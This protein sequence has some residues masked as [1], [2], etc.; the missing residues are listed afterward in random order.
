MP[1][2]TGSGIS[3][4][5]V[6]DL[7]HNHVI[8]ELD[9]TIAAIKQFS[10]SVV[11]ALLA[12]IASPNTTVV[13]VRISFS[14]PFTIASGFKSNDWDSLDSILTS[15]TNRGVSITTTVE[16]SHGLYRDLPVW[17]RLTSL[18]ESVLPQLTARGLVT[19]GGSR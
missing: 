12:S 3:A 2:K 14:L 10:C 4:L 5:D 16:F 19:G 7:R 9:L 17:Q 18:V 11:E 15:E 13:T 1:K 8:R 6:L